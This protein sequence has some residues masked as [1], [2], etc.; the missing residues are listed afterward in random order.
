MFPSAE[1][2]ELVSA[3]GTARVVS[4]TRLERSQSQRNKR[5][6]CGR[7]CVISAVRVGEAAR[8][9]FRCHEYRAPRKVGNESAA[10]HTC[11]GGSADGDGEVA[12]DL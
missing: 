5:C 4:Q 2:A 6:A 8:K 1:G 10:S 9:L 11:E 12:E 3:D 7:G